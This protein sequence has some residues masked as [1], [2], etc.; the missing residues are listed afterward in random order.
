M[1]TV[2]DRAFKP[3]DRDQ[4]VAK[5]VVTASGAGGN[6]A[7]TPNGS[8]GLVPNIYH[9]RLYLVLLPN[10]LIPTRSQS[11]LL[12]IIPANP[13]TGCLVI[14]SKEMPASTAPGKVELTLFPAGSPTVQ[15]IVDLF[16]NKGMDRYMFDA[17]GSGCLWWV[18]VG[19][20]HL[21]EAGLVEAGASR[22]L[23]MFHHEHAR[24]HP[25]RHPM[26]VR[27]GRFYW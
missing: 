20:R 1:A 7:A 11:V 4:T 2:Y 18:T 12:D 6:I 26:P 9:W 14:S 21:E 25:E 22:T 23:Q 27:Q 19:V 13:P 5:I 3:I 10:P 8:G 17:T 24:A 16:K 15:Q